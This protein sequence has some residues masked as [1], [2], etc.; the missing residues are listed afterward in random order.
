MGAA[1]GFEEFV[2]IVDGGSVTA[3]ADALGLPRPTLSR[4]L[5][6]LEERLGTRLLHRTTRRMTMTPHGE[7][8]YAKA[9]RVVYSA[10]EAEA[11][12]RR[13]DGVPRG[14]LRVSTPTAMPSTFAGWIVDFL[15][16][17]PEVSI[18][19]LSS[20]LHVD[21]VAEGFDVALRA[22]EVE[23]PSLVVRTL[24]RDARVAVASPKY[25]AEHG[26]PTQPE[27]LDEHNC[28]VGYKA[29]TVPELRW[30]LHDGR[31]VP[32]SGSFIA[33]EMGLRLDAAKRD[34]GIALVI[35]RAATTPLASGELVVVLPEVLGRRERLSLVY[36]ERTFMEPKV[37][38]FV[39]FLAARIEEARG[40]T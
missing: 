24:G 39:D 11:A 19:L 22:G 2:A 16:V 3:A 28:I 9:R 40:G 37:R 7:V 26:V 32:V 4:R 29:G 15:G 14:L 5:A 20:S 36:P 25:L 12:V 38:A 6:R 13:L 8:L 35:E 31:W 34:L 27:D 18:E 21:L 30:P 1:D 23:D 17:H 10:R 33:N